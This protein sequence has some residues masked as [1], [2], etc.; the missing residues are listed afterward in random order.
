MAHVS[1]C[2]VFLC[3]RLFT[4]HDLGSRTGRW[5]EA[6]HVFPFHI[7]R[8]R[9]PHII[10]LAA[11]DTCVYFHLLYF[12]R[13]SIKCEGHPY[14]SYLPWTGLMAVLYALG[15]P[16]VFYYLIH[17]FEDQGKCGD[18]VIQSALGPFYEPYRLGYE[19]WLIAARRQM[20]RVH[21]RRR[22]PD[23]HLHVPHLSYRRWEGCCS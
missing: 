15:V 22:S 5:L 2:C 14:E 10:L 21:Y 6:S 11:A 16:F 3:D 4:C 17:R 8:A 7:L 13:Y 1:H 19:W 20:R 12:C 23:S 18:K 9:F